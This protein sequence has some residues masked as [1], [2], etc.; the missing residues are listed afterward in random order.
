MSDEQIGCG[1]NSCV[2]RVLRPSGGMGTN[3]GCRCFKNL[4]CAADD[5]SWSNRD[6]AKKVER[7]TM[8]LRARVSKLEAALTEL[9][10]VYDVGPTRHDGILGLDWDSAP[11]TS[12]A[13]RAWGEVHAILDRGGR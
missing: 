8:R 7:D 1:D 9:V 5:G 3:G 4:V 13:G 2:F 6:D 12:A 11:D 10:T